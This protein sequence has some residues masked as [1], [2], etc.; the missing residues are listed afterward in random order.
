ML[1]NPFMTYFAGD[2]QIIYGIFQD[3]LEGL[4]ELNSY[5]GAREEWAFDTEAFKIVA[6]NMCVEAGVTLMYH[7][8][9]AANLPRAVTSIEVATKDGLKP[10]LPRSLLTPPAMPICPSCWG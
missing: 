1:V 10:L 8:F 3:M 4:R 7:G 5:G 6:E 2:K 9:A